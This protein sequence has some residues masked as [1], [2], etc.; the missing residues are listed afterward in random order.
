[1]SLDNFIPQLWAGTLLKELE[2]QK[3]L[4]ALCNRNYQGTIRNYGDVVRVSAIGDI[5]VGDYTKNSTTVSFQNLDSS[6]IS[7]TI[8]QSKYFAFEIDD[9]DAAQQNPKVMAEAMRKAAEALANTA[10][11]YIAA[12]VA[13]ASAVHTVAALDSGN[14]VSEIIELGQ[15]MDEA[16][17]PK[18]GRWLAV[19]P[20]VAAKIKLANILL[21]TNNSR[22]MTDNYIGRAHGFDIVESNNITTT[23]TSPDY[24]SRCMAGVAD[25]LSYA[26]Q[27]STVEALRRETAFADGVKG[28]HL[29]GARAI[30]PDTLFEWNVTYQAETTI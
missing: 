1:M 9:V 24:T 23:G 16:N 17:V 14:L 5:S 13:Q 12:L 7:L 26:E 8:D 30:R 25:S 29:Y 19:H 4:V 3:V 15:A 18:I 27:I 10:D 22:I 2:T 21:D 20:W 11:Q 6:E 28:L